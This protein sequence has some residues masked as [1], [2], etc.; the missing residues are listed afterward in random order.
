MYKLMLVFLLIVVS[1]IGV[2]GCESDLINESIETPKKDIA[3]Q[4]IP[5]NNKYAYSAINLPYSQ[6]TSPA[7]VGDN[8]YIPVNSSEESL[9][10]IIINLDLKTTSSVRVFNLKTRKI[11]VIYEY[12]DPDSADLIT[13]YLYND[14]VAWIN[15]N[16]KSEPQVSLYNLKTDE[17]KIVGSLHE[18]K[19][20]NLSPHIDNNT[21][22]WTDSLNGKGYYNTYNLQTGSKQHILSSAPY[23]GYAKLAS[24]DIFSIQMK[25]DHKFSDHRFG[26]YSIKDKKFTPIESKP[27]HR[28]DTYRNLVAY[29][30]ENN[31]LYIY[32]CNTDQKTNLSEILQAPVDKVDFASDG[33]L[34]A[35]FE[36]RTA[37]KLFMINK[38]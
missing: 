22:L 12:K 4:Q 33:T 20:Y 17:M 23:P 7:K 13:P 16:G 38:R 18:I 11:K 27:I 34:I 5:G 36:E 6:Y 21:L 28:F 31:D 26:Y 8:L 15:L 2:S 19:L 10:N 30:A 32:D 35:G 3:V 25:D 37:S 14:M 24:N 1:L 9:A 29:T